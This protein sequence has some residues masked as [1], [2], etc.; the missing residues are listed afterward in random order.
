MAES[1]AARRSKRRMT[2]AEEG[3]PRTAV[4]NLRSGPTRAT[5]SWLIA[6]VSIATRTAHSGAALRGQF[7]VREGDCS[8][9][10][11]VT[12]ACER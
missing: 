1:Q 11:F 4:G 12:N 7:R 10:A 5:A 2:D 9:Q 8:P 6:V 3:E